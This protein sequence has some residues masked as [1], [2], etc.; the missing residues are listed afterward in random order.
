MTALTAT[1]IFSVNGTEIEMTIDGVYAG[2][3]EIHSEG[4]GVYRV[5][6]V[7]IEKDF[8]G[9]GLYR[10]M[11]VMAFSLKKCDIIKSNNRNYLSNPIYCNWTSQEIDEKQLVWIQCF[12]SSLDFTVDQD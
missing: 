4:C 2:H 12:G 11:L 7:E 3:L 5:E 9:L 8:R 6:K 1:P 10:Q